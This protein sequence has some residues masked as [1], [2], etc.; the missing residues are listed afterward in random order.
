M[1]VSGEELVL[2]LR[3]VVFLD[4]MSSYR[5][6]SVHNFSLLQTRN[7]FLTEM[8]LKQ[9]LSIYGSSIVFF[10][11]NFKM[12]LLFRT[13]VNQSSPSLTRKT[14]TVDSTAAT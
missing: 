12:T 8:A 2:I 3:E 11:Q 9:G 6:L 4:A 7:P 1:Y 13:R 5:V 14:R 10:V